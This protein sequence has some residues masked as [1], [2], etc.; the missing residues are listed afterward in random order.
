MEKAEM[1]LTYL[2]QEAVLNKLTWDNHYAFA[3]FQL[4]NE[5]GSNLIIS[6][7]KPGRHQFSLKDSP[8]GFLANTFSDNHPVNP[9]FIPA[10]IIISKDGTVT[11]GDEVPNHLVKSFL[12]YLENVKEPSY[13]PNDSGVLASGKSERDFY[14]YVNHILTEIMSKRASKIVPSRFE[15]VKLNNRLIYNELYQS[16][17]STYPTAFCNIWSLGNGEIWAGATPES[18]LAFENRI[19]ST[20]ALAGTQALKDGQQTAT[21]GWTQKEIEEQA[22][23]SRYII[24]CFKKLRIREYSE[25]GPKTIAAGSLAH[26]SS[27]FQVD[28]SEVAFDGLADQMLELL[29]PTSAVC[30]MPR[31]ETAKF[32]EENEGY[33]RSFYAGFIGP[34]NFKKATKLFVNLRCVRI[35]D[36]IVRYYAGAGITRDSMPEREY[37]E[38]E[39]K[40]EVMKRLIK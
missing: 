31:V 19:F 18:L 27:Q 22:M 40:M 35:K 11:I 15:D 23:V 16:I 24:N 1:D 38:T 29:H 39:M 33:D 14:D 13:N 17:C 20:V 21:I 6:L 2:R 32:I 34:V 10:D 9:W 3:C 5:T 37:V 28:L 30:G 8:T 25:N 4:P 7:T 26:L 36:N 12:E